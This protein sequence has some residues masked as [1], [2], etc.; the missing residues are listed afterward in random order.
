MKGLVLAGGKGTRLRPLTHTMPKQLIPVANKPILDYV[1]DHMRQAHITSIGIVVSP[2]TGHYI[3]E[4]LDNTCADL[5]I[6]YILQEKPLGLAHAVQVSH[7]FLGDD[8]FLM[9]LGD[10]L[11]KHGIK[12]CIELFNTSKSDAVIML[13]EVEDARMFGVADIDETGNIKQLV[14]KPPDPPSNLAVVGVYVFSPMI[15]QAIAK[16]Q[17]SQRGELEITDA[18]QKMMTMGYS[19][20]SFQ[21]NGWWLDT[22]KKSDLLEANRVILDELSTSKIE[23]T[24]DTKSTIKGNVYIEAGATIHR[25]DIQ[26]PAIIGSKTVLEDTNIGPYTSVGNSCSIKHSEIL[27]SVVLNDVLIHNISPMQDS[28]IGNNATIRQKTS[29]HESIEFMVGDNTEVDL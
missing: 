18:I 11:I 24:I 16:I 26:G 25:T 17:P 29:T 15:H 1:M 9:F 21:L 23:G 28:V 5:D 7:E 2:D 13:K 3:K 12:E 8:P 10:N 4:A 27:N 19:V 22:G 6:T 20:R 14:E